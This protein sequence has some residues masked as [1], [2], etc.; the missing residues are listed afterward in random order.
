MKLVSE[1]AAK[2]LAPS[3][4]KLV[5]YILVIGGFRKLSKPTLSTELKCLICGG[6]AHI[7]PYHT[8]KFNGLAWMC[9]AR[10]CE[11]TKQKLFGGSTV[12]D[13]I[14]QRSLEWPLFC[15]INGIGD[16][17]HDIRF[18]NIKQSDAM[19]NSM[20]SFFTSDKA[21]ML[22]QGEKGAGKTYASMGMCEYY[23]RRSNSCIFT[24]QKKMMN[25][26]LDTFKY[27]GVTNYIN[28]ITSVELLVI[29]DFGTGTLATGFMQFFMGL[30][31]DRMQ[32]KKRKTILTTNLNDDA[33]SAVCGDAL[34]DRINTGVLLIFD[35][36]T[37][38]I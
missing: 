4:G 31:N 2:M 10:N 13:P 17:H 7:T 21:I 32:W 9:I 8:D 33:M 36:P 6:T 1:I 18:D 16:R 28:R 5:E 38:R 11:A 37:R 14:M 15:E 27:Q 35:G 24:T 29:D 20:H 19:L 34:S 23:T 26:W 12:I 22:M 30:I 25:D 3:D